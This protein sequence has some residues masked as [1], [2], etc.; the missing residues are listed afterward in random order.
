M[1]KITAWFL[2]G[3]A[4]CAEDEEVD[5]EMLGGLGRGE[6]WTVEFMEEGEV[7]GRL[8][9][10]EVGI[11]ERAEVAWVGNEEVR[12]RE[13]LEGLWGG[14]GRGRVGGL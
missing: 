6:D 4:Y 1:T 9:R 10:H 5:V 3:N 8:P 14:L 13:R 7:R 11:L 12:A 2:V